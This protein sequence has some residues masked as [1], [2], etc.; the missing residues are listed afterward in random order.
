[1]MKSVALVVASAQAANLTTETR[2]L[3][4]FSDK[5]LYAPAPSSDTVNTRMMLGSWTAQQTCSEFDI[6]FFSAW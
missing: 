5:G 6:K 1:M 2:D 4:G 3:S